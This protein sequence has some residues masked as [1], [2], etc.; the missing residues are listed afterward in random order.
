[1]S[2]DTNR[3]THLKLE[4]VKRAVSV[5]LRL[6]WAS[7]PESC[8]ALL[9]LLPLRRQVWHAKYANNEIYLLCRA[10]E[11]APTPE[12]LSMYPSRGDLVY[13]PLPEGIPL[14]KG[15]PGIGPGDPALD[16]AYFYEANNSLLGGPHGPLPG[17][18][19]ATVEHLDDIERMA[20]ACRDVWF[21]GAVEEEMALAI[22]PAQG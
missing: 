19:V 13:L 4:L 21:S 15:L 8:R 6:R 7:A 1:M 20:V 11:P 5:P 2:N 10:P 9:S 18:I 14:P 3:P 22:E 17:T 12:S 16:V